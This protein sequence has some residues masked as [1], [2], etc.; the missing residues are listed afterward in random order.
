[1]PATSLF[2]R[3]ATEAAELG[4]P[5][6]V[7]A[8]IN[9]KLSQNSQFRNEVGSGELAADSAKHGDNVGIRYHHAAYSQQIRIERM[10]GANRI[11]LVCRGDSEA[12]R[13]HQ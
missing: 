8:L 5:S 1:M 11:G 10:S 3:N 7:G 9:L 2:T 6:A 13:P 4:E 12:L